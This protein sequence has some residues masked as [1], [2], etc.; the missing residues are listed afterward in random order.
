M[1]LP[2]ISLCCL[3][4]TLE[5]EEHDDDQDDEDVEDDESYEDD[6]GDEDDEVF[7]SS[8]G[9]RNTETTTKA[10]KASKTKPDHDADGNSPVDVGPEAYS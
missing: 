4:A 9:T 5:D 7:Y 6:E 2:T 8:S 1:T 3:A 10:K